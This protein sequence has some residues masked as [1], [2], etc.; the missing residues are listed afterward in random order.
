MDNIGFAR[1]PAQVFCR[2]L[3]VLE[4]FAYMYVI[5][6][7]YYFNIMLCTIIFTYAFT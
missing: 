1:L 7:C 6:M 5:N 2:D 4:A 3:V